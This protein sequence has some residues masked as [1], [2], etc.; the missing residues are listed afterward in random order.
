MMLDPVTCLILCTD[1]SVRSSLRGSLLLSP[2]S[3]S[4]Y[5]TVTQVIDQ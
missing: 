4:A 1:I 5:G 2:H 3:R